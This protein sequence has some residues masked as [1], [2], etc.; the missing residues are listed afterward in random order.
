MIRRT[1][2]HGFLSRLDTN[3]DRMYYHLLV[4]RG[5]TLG[6]RLMRNM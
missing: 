2:G 1:V 3:V 6:F 4:N 5:K